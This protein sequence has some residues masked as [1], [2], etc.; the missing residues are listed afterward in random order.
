MLSRACEGHRR[1]PRSLLSPPTLLRREPLA[2][3]VA[4]HT[5]GC[6]AL[7]LVLLS[8]PPPPCGN[9][10]ITEA[11]YCVWLFRWSLGI[12]FSPSGLGG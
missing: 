6:L 3:Y 12:K 2:V 7:E 10:G 8:P 4:L 11:C 9:A 5:S 1:T